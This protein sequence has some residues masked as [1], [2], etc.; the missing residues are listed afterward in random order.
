MAARAGALIIDGILAFIV[1]GEA[2]VLLA[3]QEHHA[4]ASYGLEPVSTVA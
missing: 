2:I 1:L 3:G 4:N